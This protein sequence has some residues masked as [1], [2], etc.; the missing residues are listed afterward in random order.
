MEELSERVVDS[1]TS[2]YFSNLARVLV[3]GMVVFFNSSLRW[4]V[5]GSECFDDGMIPG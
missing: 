5:V 4:L 1:S 3:A 2:R